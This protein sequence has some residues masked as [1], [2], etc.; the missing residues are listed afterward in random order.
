MKSHVFEE[1]YQSQLPRISVRRVTQ[2]RPSR[3]GIDE[4]NPEDI[5]YGEYANGAKYGEYVDLIYLDDNILRTV[6]GRV[7][8]PNKTLD[9]LVI[10]LRD[11]KKFYLIEVKEVEHGFAFKRNDIVDIKTTSLIQGNS[12]HEPSCTW[13]I[14]FED[15]SRRNIETSF[16]S[17]FTYGNVVR[18]NTMTN[19][20]ILERVFGKGV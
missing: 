20:F 11:D 4:I 15:G 14:T 13:T 9:E 19:A 7:D 3:G 17:Y 1:T 8:R 2:T 18:P 5:I 10:L 12:N 16:Q 6:S